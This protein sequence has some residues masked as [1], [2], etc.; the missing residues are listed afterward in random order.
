MS[1]HARASLAA[2]LVLLAACSVPAAAQQRECPAADSARV[3]WSAPP[4][5]P[6]DAWRAS[7]LAER[8]VA[9]GTELVR[10]A[11]DSMPGAGDAE[12]EL[13]WELD[14]VIRERYGDQPMK[15]AVLTRVEA[16]STLSRL[17]LPLPSGG[18]VGI[19]ESI[20]ERIRRL[21][22]RPVFRDGC[23]IASLSPI[24]IEILPTRRIGTAAPE[25]QAPPRSPR[26]PGDRWVE[27]RRGNEGGGAWIDTTSIVQ[28]RENVFRF[29]LQYPY[30]SVM[31]RVSDGLMVDGQEALVEF[32][33]RRAR[34][35]T[36][37][38][39][40]LLGE[41]VVEEEELAEPRRNWSTGTLPWLRDAYC[42][43]LRQAQPGPPPTPPNP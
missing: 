8:L 5:V 28:V 14:R 34:D 33:C 23:P 2:A 30:P 39:K 15:V 27:V 9:P 13:V 11:F 40:L 6:D 7:L 1:V 18:R 43:L 21:R 20:P 31:R 17:L 36:L 35:R 29:T 22:Y 12:R 41:R 4:G 19:E 37:A 10:I 25:A 3:A 24:I 32:D 38:S 26:A 16:D 42:P